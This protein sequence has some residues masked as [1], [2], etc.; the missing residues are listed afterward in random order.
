M[1]YLILLPIALVGLCLY[2]LLKALLQMFK[3]I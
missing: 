2:Y 3:I 1:G